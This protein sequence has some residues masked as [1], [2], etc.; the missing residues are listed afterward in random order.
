MSSYPAV[1]RCYNHYEKMAS[2]DDVETYLED[3]ILDGVSTIGKELGVGAYGKVFIVKYCENTYAAKEIHSIL[4]QSANEKEKQILY[5]NFLRECYY[6]SKICHPNVVDFKGVYH[7]TPASKS[8]LP[9]MVM[10]LMDESLTDYVKKILSKE[11][12]YSILYDVSCGLSYLHSFKPPLIHRD[13]SP[14]NILLILY[15]QKPWPVAKISDLGVAKVM[16]ADSQA[17][18][19]V[20]TKAPGTVDFMP[21]EALNE[22][23]HYD[24]PLDIFSYAGIILHVVNQEWPTPSESVVRNSSTNEPLHVLSEYQRRQKHLNKMSG[25]DTVLEPLVKACLDDKPSKCPATATVLKIM[26]FV[27]VCLV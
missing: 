10:E 5:R 6:C 17:T 27:M 20:L 22:N 18:K 14:N 9:I 19:C 12:K 23:P 15:K 4:V 13:L 2:M 3:L 16:K 24:T 7:P 8:S 26:E 25:I 1:D 21:P 11:T